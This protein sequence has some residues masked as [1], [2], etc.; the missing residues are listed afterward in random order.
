MVGSSPLVLPS[1][2]SERCPLDG[3]TLGLWLIW[4]QG[5]SQRLR[6]PQ[7]RGFPATE[8][9]QGKSR[10]ILDVRQPL[11][12]G[13]DTGASSSF[14]WAALTQ[15]RGSS[16]SQSPSATAREGRGTEAVRGGPPRP[17]PSCTRVHP[18]CTRARP[19]PPKSHSNCPQIHPNPTQPPLDP[20]SR[21]LSACGNPSG[22]GD[23]IRPSWGKPRFQPGLVCQFPFPDELNPNRSR[24][25]MGAGKLLLELQ[26]EVCCCLGTSW[27]EQFVLCLWS[28]LFGISSGCPCCRNWCRFG[29]FGGFLQPQQRGEP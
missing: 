11:L 3:L 28:K 1:G 22:A 20:E 4:E 16:P 7:S 23:G 27:D 9:E 26:G 17:H 12:T 14:L 18:D 25:A 6:V 13:A 21:L 10:G 5:L 2:G 24:G 15:P 29:A 8:Q 19:A